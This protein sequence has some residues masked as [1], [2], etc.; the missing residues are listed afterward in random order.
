MCIRD[1]VVSVPAINTIADGTAVQTP[2]DKLFPYLQANVDE[3]ITIE[4]SELTLSFL[5]MA[6][7]HKMI[8]ENSGLLTVAA[9]KHLDFK[10]KKVVS[11]LS[12]GNMDVL[13][14]AT[15]VQ[16]G[17]ILRDRIFTAVSYTHLPGN[18]NGMVHM[19][20]HQDPPQEILDQSLI[21]IP[22]FHQIGSYADGSR[23][24]KGL[25]LR[26]SSAAGNGG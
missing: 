16:N 12:G 20:H 13:T 24:L 22:C 1:R 15:V 10:G 18:G 9:L 2:G 5:D 23:L 3:V 7:N 4:D 11:V 14:M 21:F 26:K 8:V 19:V 17:L 25:W 6:E